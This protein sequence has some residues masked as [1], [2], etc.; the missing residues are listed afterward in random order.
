LITEN[1]FLSQLPCKNKMINIYK[2]VISPLL[3]GYKTISPRKHR[4]YLKKGCKAKF[5]TYGKGSNRRLE[6]NV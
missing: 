4:M 6:K 1:I 3:Y 5:L 2:T